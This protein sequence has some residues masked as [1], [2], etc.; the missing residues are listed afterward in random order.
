[1]STPAKNRYLP[2]YV[3]PPGETIRESVEALGMTQNEFAKRMGITPKT[4][5]KLIHGGAPIRP[6]TALALE[7]VLNVPARFWTNLEANYQEFLARQNEAK[8]LE[9]HSAWVGSFPYL[10]M[11]K[12]AYVNP[13]KEAWQR[14]RELLQ[15]FGV[16]SPDDWE[17]L[18]AKP[19]ACFRHSAALKSSSHALS[20]WLRQ[21]EKNAATLDLPAYDPTRFQ[22]N[23]SAVRE[24]VCEP[25]EVFE[26]EMIRLCRESGVALLFE[27]PLPKV[28]ASGAC[29]W[30]GDRP[31]ILLSL[32][33]KTDDHFWF[34]FFHESK[35][36]LQCVRKRL[37]VDVPGEEQNDPKEKEANNFA[38]ST[39][40]PQARWSEFIQQRDFSGPAIQSFAKQVGITPGI[41]VGQ[42]QFLKKLR[43]ETTLNSLKCRFAWAD[44][45]G[46]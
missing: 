44:E 29:R 38:R 35:H 24:L 40:I 46:N 4:V 22:K 13:V 32:R 31:V 39:L 11:A 20:A 12:L 19:D 14:A 5:T 28:R 33:Y 27:R 3:S 15:F 6:D 2:D 41:V 25:V 30:L 21:G 1:M 18:W 23:V 45:A 16:A 8:E 37:F 36:V 17:V 43:W 10:D 26:P 42:L 7:K 34:T 9:K